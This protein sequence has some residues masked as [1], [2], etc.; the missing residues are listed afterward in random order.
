MTC[1]LLLF[2][3]SITPASSITNS[4]HLLMSSTI[5]PRASKLPPPMASPKPGAV[6]I[7]HHAFPHIMDQI[8]AVASHGALL[9]LRAASKAYR[10]Q[11]DDC[12]ARHLVFDGKHAALRAAE[13]RHPGLAPTPGGGVA[14]PE[15]LANTSVV[16]FVRVG[17]VDAPNLLEMSDLVGATTLR[18]WSE[19]CLDLATLLPAIATLVV[20]TWPHPPP[21]SEEVRWRPVRTS[22]EMPLRTLIIN[23]STSIESMHVV[24]HL[25]D[26]LE[27]CTVEKLVIIFTD[28]V[29]VDDVSTDELPALMLSQTP[30]SGGPVGRH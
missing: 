8:M 20:F 9:S 23:L 6:V 18:T 3:H 4:L 7:D 2:I 16:D 22:S 15:L 1:F 24:P 25:V 26:P 11:V 10:K 28:P 30:R 19:S 5:A 29:G 17:S 21:F 13:G 14:R 27:L 12:L